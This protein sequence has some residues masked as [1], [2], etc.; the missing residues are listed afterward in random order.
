MTNPKP[1]GETKTSDSSRKESEKLSARV[2][3][4]LITLESNLAGW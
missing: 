1:D 4:A 2:Q 3:I